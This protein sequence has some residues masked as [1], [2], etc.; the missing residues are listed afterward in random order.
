MLGI[1]AVLA[2]AHGHQRADLVFL[3]L[4]GIIDPPRDGVREAIRTLLSS[5]A[6]L[7]MLTGDSEDTAI[8][9]GTTPD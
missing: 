7:K 5:G 8:A 2:L 6:H 4:V 3:G 1:A 9:V